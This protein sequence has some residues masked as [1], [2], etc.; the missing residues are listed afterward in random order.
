ME[1][2]QQLAETDLDPETREYLLDV[3]AA[4]ATPEEK[5]DAAATLAEFG[6][7]APEAA[8]APAAAAAALLAG[9]VT[10]RAVKCGLRAT[11]STIV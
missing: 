8:A 2:A 10:L 7:A 3:W 9:P 5:A 11:V 4:A 1:L 6:L